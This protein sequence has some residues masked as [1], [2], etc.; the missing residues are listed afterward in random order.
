MGAQV[1]ENFNAI[2][3]KEDGSGFMDDKQKEWARTMGNILRTQ[4]ARKVVEPDGKGE[5]A[6]LRRR[7]FRLVAGDKDQA[8]FF[9]KSVASLVA[10]NVLSMSITWYD[11]P[12]WVDL[13]AE[14]QPSPWLSPESS[15]EPSP[16]A[17]AKQVD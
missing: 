10:L 16:S 5:F 11:Q 3:K 9:E 13:F 1:L 7:A 17:Q 14:V 12:A 4:S 6:I 8:A 2:R 15:P